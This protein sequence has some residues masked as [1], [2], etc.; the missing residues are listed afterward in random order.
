[1]WSTDVAFDPLSPRRIR[2]VG[3]RHVNVVGGRRV[4]WS[5]PSC[6]PCRRLRVWM[7]GGSTTF[8]LGQRDE[9]TIPS[10]LARVAWDGGYALDVDNRGVPGDAHWEEVQRLAWDL[11]NEAPPDLVVFYDGVNEMRSLEFVTEGPARP[12]SFVKENFWT[13]YLAATG[14]EGTAIAESVVGRRPLGTPPGAHRV[15]QPGAPEL[16]ARGWGDLAAQRYEKSRSTSEALADAYGVPVAYFWQPGL[17]HRADIPGE[18]SMSGGGFSAKRSAAASEA[19]DP[20]V[21][22]L[23]RSFDGIEEPIFY[24]SNHTNELGARIIA[25]ALFEHLEPAFSTENQRQPS[26][27][28]GA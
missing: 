1:M 13:Q 5:P 9:H 7:Y 20:E 3:T 11:A 27:T 21:V 10:E 16:D 15:P 14:E 22:D 2:D 25:E 18:P 28:G 4:T 17:E 6:H 12:V 24:D 8:G 26:D 23:S 19:L